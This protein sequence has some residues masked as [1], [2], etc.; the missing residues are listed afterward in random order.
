MIWLFYHLKNPISKE[1]DR[2]TLPVL[3]EKK[4]KNNMSMKNSCDN[5]FTMLK[6]EI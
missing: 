2:R 1:E 3:L 4:K 6:R 5:M